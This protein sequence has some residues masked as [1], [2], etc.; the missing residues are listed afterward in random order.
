MG[1]LSVHKTINLVNFYK[2]NNINVLFNS[3]YCSEFNC[4]K[5]TFRSVKKKIYNKLFKNIDQI[6]KEIKNI[7]EDNTFCHILRANF[8]ETLEK[9]KLFIDMN[10]NINFKIWHSL[11][12][13]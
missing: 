2:D 13:K 12:I 7:F 11:K 5:L 10:N 8:K 1:N 3:P 9:Y 4:V 6:E